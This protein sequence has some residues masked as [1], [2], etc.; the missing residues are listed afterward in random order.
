MELSELEFPAMRRELVET[1]TS[2]SDRDYQQ[3]VWIDK[4]YPRP[5]FFD[6]LTMTV[7]IF[8]DL[9]VNDDDFDQYIGAFLVSSDEATAVERVYRTLDALIDDLADSP[10]SR[11]LSDPRWTDV[12]SAAAQA[13]AVLNKTQ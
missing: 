1:M 2:L 11:Y 9:I 13:K 12:V 3:R 6:D 8:H 4:N 7:N 5:N 10:D